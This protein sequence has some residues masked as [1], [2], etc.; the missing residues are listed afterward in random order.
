VTRARREL[1]TGLAMV[2]PWVV[3]TLVFFAGPAVVSAVLS[4]TD[5]TLL[6]PPVWVG[7]GN[8]VELA[9]DGLFWRCLRNTVVFAVASAAGSVVLSVALALLLEEPLRG[10]G[11]VR[12]VVF[13]P[14]LVPAVSAC[15]TWT[16]LYNPEFGLVNTV[17]RGVGLS[18]RD[19]LGDARLALPALIVMGLWTIG[20]SLLVATAALGGV[21]RSLYE[22]ADLDGV[23]RW[24]RVRHVTL[25]LIA[26]AV[27]FNAVMGVIWGLQV[28][29]PPQ[30]MTRGGP[31]DSTR[32][33]AIYVYSSGFL[34]G[35]MGYASAMAWVQVVVA[36]LAALLL[37]RFGRRHGF[38]RGVA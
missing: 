31:A 21:P 36:V 3:G 17:A 11:W 30:V 5:S 4:L 9:G 14:T 37:V 26:P 1:F 33:L 23:S 24:G 8:Y 25:P 20:T 13:A 19:W 10:R 18:G 22:A 16:W 38:S 27:L 7:A 32:T 34:H 29:T 35:R 15:V 2:S 28:F 6:E 12:A